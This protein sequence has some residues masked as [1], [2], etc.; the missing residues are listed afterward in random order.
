M[1]MIFRNIG[2][3]LLLV[4]PLFSAL[5]TDDLEVI[6]PTGMPLFHDHSEQVFF[7]PSSSYSITIRFIETSMGILLVR[8]HR[9]GGVVQQSHS[10]ICPTTSIVIYNSSSGN[11]RE[12]D[13]T[14]KNVILE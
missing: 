2:L 14:K 6:S 8:E 7:R 13:I 4:S 12:E 1:K 3:M 10:I 11:V 9:K 5:L